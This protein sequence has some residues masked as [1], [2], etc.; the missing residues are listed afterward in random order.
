[1]KKRYTTL[2]RSPVTIAGV[3]IAVISFGLILFLMLLELLATE[4]KPYMGIIAFVILPGILIV[5][6]ILI[7]FGAYREHMREKSGHFRH[8]NF[9]VLDLNNPKHR[10]AFTISPTIS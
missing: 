2:F 7:A 4:H 9:P 3:L 1:M 5:G 10:R 6:L 8:Y